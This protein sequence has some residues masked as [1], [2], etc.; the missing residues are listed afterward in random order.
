MKR[1]F[2]FFTLAMVT[3]ISIFAAVVAN[4]DKPLKGEWD[5]KPEKLWQVDGFGKELLSQID[6]FVVHDNGDIYLFDRGHFQFFVF[7]K[8]GKSKF[9]FGRKG[10]GPGEIKVMLDFFLVDNHLIVCDMGKMHFFDTSGTYEKSLPT[11]T[12]IGIAP[13]LI[14]DENR[15]VKTRMA[16]D[17]SV[18]ETLEIFDLTAKTS[19]YLHG[20]PLPEDNKKGNNGIMLSINSG[21][22]VNERRPDFTAAR[23]GDK[24]LWGKNDTYLIKTNDFTGKEHFAFSLKGRKLKKITE[25]YKEKIVSRMTIRTTGGPSPEEIKKRL[26]RTYPDLST[27][28]S[29]IQA[30]KNGL[31]YV[32]VSDAVRENGQEIDIFSPTGRYL[33]HTDFAMP[34]GYRVL[35]NGTVFKDDFLYLLVEDADGIITFHKYRVQVP[36][37]LPAK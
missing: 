7:D 21:H 28:F 8:K 30:G 4:P 25:A 20:G 32:F 35:A 2:I 34:E 13:L 18:K 1:F 19:I 12:T 16:Q 15:T 37:Q 5:L 27:Y 6:K 36:P 22:E 31:I 23:Y 11:S 26:L 17:F 10:E 33:Y 3:V 24:I 14:I 9:S 29:R